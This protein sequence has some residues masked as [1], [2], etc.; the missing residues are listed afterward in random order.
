MEEKKPYREQLV[1]EKQA[2]EMRN[3]IFTSFEVFLLLVL[4]MYGEIYDIPFTRII[5][6]LFA[7]GIKKS[8]DALNQS[9]DR[10]LLHYDADQLYLQAAAENK[11]ELMRE[12]LEVWER[13][14]EGF[15]KLALVDPDTGKNAL[16]LAVQ[17]Q[18]PDSVNLLMGGDREIGE[19]PERRDQESILNHQDHEGNTPVHIAIKMMTDQ[20]DSKAWEILFDVITGRNEELK[21]TYTTR[22]PK[23]NKRI[24]LK[25]TNL[26]DESV[27]KLM[28]V[29]FRKL[30]QHN[31]VLQMKPCLSLL[32]L[33][34][35]TDFGVKSK[36]NALHFAAHAGAKDAVKFLVL[37]EKARLSKLDSTSESDP[38][39]DNLFNHQDD[40]GNT[41][42]HE[43][44]I[45]LIKAKGKD[46]TILLELLTQP[47]QD[48]SEMTRTSLKDKEKESGAISS[49]LNNFGLLAGRGH[50]KLNLGANPYIDASLR[51]NA[52]ESL[53]ELAEKLPG[54][55]Q[56]SVVI[57]LINSLEHN[58]ELTLGDESKTDLV[59]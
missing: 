26:Q 10:A 12:L 5:S 8:Y 21:G 49:Q 42:I 56:K 52:G 23:C 15:D 48:G 46:Y 4:F 35:L 38:L 31:R 51:N 16:H 13:K 17:E 54:S 58:T 55:K 50:A 33:N 11:M 28:G 44:L 41:P 7:P 37:M 43:A 40:K 6:F 59:S 39:L 36:R 3:M 27:E 1:R 45:D 9:A 24:N 32:T 2:L 25:I 14:G 18:A 34:N 29:L 19:R 30:A 22:L 53:L 57:D 47:G 20:F